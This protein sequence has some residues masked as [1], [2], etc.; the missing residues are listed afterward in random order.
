MGYQ[1]FTLIACAV[2]NFVATAAVK[3]GFF[4]KVG[5]DKF[6]MAN[7]AA[8]ETLAYEQIAVALLSLITDFVFH[9]LVSKTYC[10][11]I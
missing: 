10:D 1:P 9:P 3:L 8:G 5:V 2:I 6:A 11:D 4:K 7:G